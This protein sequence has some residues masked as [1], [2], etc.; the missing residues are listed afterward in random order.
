MVLFS[1]CV[2]LQVENLNEP[3][4]SHFTGDPETIKELGGS[5]FKTL[6]NGM[7]EYSGPGQA[8]ATMADQNTCSWGFG[9]IRELSSEPRHGYIN[10]ETF[11]YIYTTKDFWENCYQAISTATDIL[12]LLKNEQ[13]SDSMIPDQN[14]LEVWGLFIS[15][16]AHGYLGLIFDKAH[17]VTGNSETDSLGYTPWKDVINFSLAQL[18][19]SITLA[20]MNSFVIPAEWMGGEPYTNV[21]LAELS[22]SY[23]ARFLTYSSRNKTHNESIDWN[24]VLQYAQKGIQKDLAPEMGDRYDFYNFFLVYSIYPGWVRIDHRI[25]N[26]MDPDYPCYWPCVYNWGIRD[27]MWFTADSK[28]PGPAESEDARL[29][30]DFEYLEENNFRPDR[31][32]Y[33]FSHYRHKRYNDFMARIWYGDIPHPSFMV[34]ENELLIAE[35]MVKTGN[36]TGAVEILND[37]NGARKLRGNLPDITFANTEEILWTI[38]YERDIELIN[39]GIGI[40]YFDMRRRDNLQ[41]GTILHFPVPVTEL[42]ITQ[43]ENYT[44]GGTPDGENVSKGSWTGLDGITVP[45]GIIW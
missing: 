32:M 3:D 23:A 37:P 28:D 10:S 39:T 9:S 5:A 45:P 19:K 24:R 36:L 31:G 26:L 41:K 35:A 30:S 7:Q 13:E 33:H 34:W 29:E 20:E 38:F 11:A 15:G 27:Y 44:I 25:I 16:V 40:S 22:N 42:K 2:N 12:N 21:E 17:V 1:E 18:D 6:H 14:M 43:D 4:L 8:M